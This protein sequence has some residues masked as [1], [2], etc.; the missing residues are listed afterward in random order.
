MYQ[1]LTAN[2]IPNT[3]QTSWF[4]TASIKKERTA[5]AMVNPRKA[6][7][8]DPIDRVDT[9]EPIKA[10]KSAI[11]TKV[12]AP[13]KPAD[14]TPV[15]LATLGFI[16]SL[17]AVFGV[18]LLYANSNQ[19]KESL[20]AG[21]A[22]VK[23]SI[24]LMEN[25]LN[26][27]EKKLVNRPTEETITTALNALKQELQAIKASLPA[28]P[29]PTK[30]TNN[31]L[32]ERLKTVENMIYALSQTVNTLGER[33]DA[34]PKNIENLQEQTAVVISTI[35]YGKRL[36]Y[37]QQLYIGGKRGGEA[38]FIKAYMKK[39]KEQALP[40]ATQLMQI[41]ARL[42]EAETLLNIFGTP[43]TI[44]MWTPLI[45]LIE[46]LDEEQR[47]NPA[48]MMLL[49]KEAEANLVKTLEPLLESEQPVEEESLSN[50]QN[51]K[52]EVALLH[53]I[54]QHYANPPVPFSEDEKW[55]LAQESFAS[56]Y[57]PAIT[58]CAEKNFSLAFETPQLLLNFSSFVEGLHCEVLEASTQA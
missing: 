45:Q 5:V 56:R 53:K 18:G 3:I 8:D 19:A 16:A 32:S 14:K 10:E 23:T 2:N 49:L 33:M 6:V 57:A 13:E 28:K 36:G 47:K 52:D 21:M 30:R 1:Q 11:P 58:Q 40:V 15:M 22:E 43:S 37:E 7:K 42:S 35:E 48:V 39:S 54:F 50:F 55:L 17:G 51:L 20:S 38:G 31:P 46:G 4:S 24:G 44:T 29:D 34:V 12:I 27:L 41:K 26:N 9:F 25:K